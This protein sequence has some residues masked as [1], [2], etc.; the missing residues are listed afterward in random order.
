MPDRSLSKFTVAH[1]IAR[2]RARKIR[3]ENMALRA[4]VVETRIDREHARA[5]AADQLDR[6]EDR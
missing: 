1:A 5:L 3:F 4:R 2:D 6:R